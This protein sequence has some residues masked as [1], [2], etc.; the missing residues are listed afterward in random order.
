MSHIMVIAESEFTA[1]AIEQ[2]LTQRGY[3]VTTATD[4]T[5]IEPSC[6]GLVFDLVVLGLNI[7]SKVK[8]AILLQIREYCDGTPVLDMCLPGACVTGADFSLTSDS[9]ESLSSAVAAMLLQKQNRK[10]S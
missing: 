4:F 5:H 9:F 2:A 10:I 6:A 8:Q 7:R 1:N 3:L